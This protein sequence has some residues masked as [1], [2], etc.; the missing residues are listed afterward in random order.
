MEIASFI[1]LRCYCSIWIILVVTTHTT[2]C[3]CVKSFSYVRLF[4]TPWT[5]AHQAPLSMEFPRQQYWS[6]LPFPS[7][8]DFSNPGIKPMFPTLAGGFFTPE[9]PEKP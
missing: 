5:V 1:P 2:L 3:V 4:T 6:G 9:M 8:E 7:P